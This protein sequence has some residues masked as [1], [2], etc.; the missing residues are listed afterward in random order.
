MLRQPKRNAVPRRATNHT[1]SNVDFVESL[2]AKEA[3]LAQAGYRDAGG[4]IVIQLPSSALEELAIKGAVICLDRSYSMKTCVNSQT[5][6]E[7]QYNASNAC[8]LSGVEFTPMQAITF[9]DVGE[10]F[11]IPMGTTREELQNILPLSATAPRYG[12]H[13][14]PALKLVKEAN[15]M[16]IMTDGAIQDVDPAI[17]YIM[18]NLQSPKIIAVGIGNS[19]DPKTVNLKSTEFRNLKRLVDLGNSHSQLFLCKDIHA[20]EDSMES[21]WTAQATVDGQALPVAV[22]PTNVAYAVALAGQVSGSSFAARIGNVTYNVEI[23]D[24]PTLQMQQNMEFIQQLWQDELEVQEAAAQE[25]ATFRARGLTT[26]IVKLLLSNAA[27]RIK[28]GRIG[29]I[30]LKTLGK[31]LRALA[32]QRKIPDTFR[33]LLVALEDPDAPP[34]HGTNRNVTQAE[35]LCCLISLDKELELLQALLQMPRSTLAQTPNTDILRATHPLYA[36]VV[37]LRRR[38]GPE[39]TALGL[40]NQLRATEITGEVQFVTICYDSIME[41]ARQNGLQIT[42]DLFDDLSQLA[43]VFDAGTAQAWLDAAPPAA[44]EHRVQFLESLRI[45]ASPDQEPMLLPVISRCSDDE[46]FLIGMCGTMRLVLN[47]T[48]TGAPQDSNRT[49]ALGMLGVLTTLLGVSQPSQH[50]KDLITQLASTCRAVGVSLTT[51][52]GTYAVDMHEQGTTQLPSVWRNALAATAR[53]AGDLERMRA[54]L[55]ANRRNLLQLVEQVVSDG[56]P[57]CLPA[58][59]DLTTLGDSFDG[60]C[61][62]ATLLV[63][64]SSQLAYIVGPKRIETARQALK[65]A[66]AALREQQLVTF[67]LRH[68]T[69]VTGTEKNRTLGEVLGEKCTL[70]NTGVLSLLPAENQYNVWSRIKNEPVGQDT[71]NAE[72]LGKLLQSASTSNDRDAQRLQELVQLTSRV[73]SSN[74][75]ALDLCSSG[76]LEIIATECAIVLADANNTRARN[77]FEQ[78]VLQRLRRIVFG[79]RQQG[80]W[81]PFSDVANV[82]HGL[83]HILTS[84]GANPGI[85][86]LLVLQ[87]ASEQDECMSIAKET[88]RSIMKTLGTDKE[89]S[90]VAHASIA[91]RP[92]FRQMIEADAEL[93]GFPATDPTFISLILSEF[94][95]LL[96]REGSV[97]TAA[98]Q[99]RLGTLKQTFNIQQS[100]AELLATMTNLKI[101]QSDLLKAKVC[102]RF[103]YFPVMPASLIKQDP[104]FARLWQLAAKVSRLQ[105]IMLDFHHRQIEG[106]GKQNGLVHCL[107]HEPNCFSTEYPSLSKND[108]FW[109]LACEVAEG[110]I[111]RPNGALTEHTVVFSKALVDT[112][113]E[114]VLEPKHVL[115]YKKKQSGRYKAVVLTAIC[116]ADGLDITQSSSARA[117]ILAYS[118]YTPVANTTDPI[119]QCSDYFHDESAKLKLFKLLAN[120]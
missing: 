26:H 76:E 87:A 81:I 92:Q 116:I 119:V 102:E 21:I 59:L 18:R 47:T 107:I 36:L 82:V 99:R 70:C 35:H 58:L 118:T 95:A 10:T 54:G 37:G 49:Y 71:V 48:V 31:A 113:R 43:G 100:L 53:G 39:G 64:T 5:Y 57:N 61:A 67:V 3:P 9:D 78:A 73:T 51:A 65:E 60:R 120:L 74:I 6:H 42:G 38:T 90:A 66:A 62:A 112:F 25:E 2:I 104:G 94:M 1:S 23:C 117:D 83:E 50:H 29:R 84:L 109:D 28:R 96:T 89:L 15:T 97:D 114:T 24:E 80:I 79:S 86:A 56:G 55:K 30:S 75:R 17:T 13:L 20:L 77:L 27:K 110:A 91:L 41:L 108:A 4:N 32:K 11:T 106:G 22:S 69:S 44:A 33:S 115:D 7:L 72:L 101:Q 12:T 16:I 103:H 85:V 34:F 63:V 14:L 68:I 98:I 93:L 52:L 111:S 45:F 19:F 88:V 105:Q 40:Q 46:G 8:I